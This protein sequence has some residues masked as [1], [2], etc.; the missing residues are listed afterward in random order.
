MSL[1]IPAWILNAAPYVTGLILIGLL[2]VMA[3]YIWRES[4]ADN[5]HGSD[6]ADC[7]LLLGLLM[8]SII[9]IVFFVVFSMLSVTGACSHRLNLLA[10]PVTLS[11]LGTVQTVPHAPLPLLPIRA[12]SR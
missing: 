4:V 2:L 7:A 5:E 3:V 1:C 9:A 12:P 6:S 11:S 10:P 8:L